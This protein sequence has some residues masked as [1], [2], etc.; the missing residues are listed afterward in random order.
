MK[1]ITLPNTKLITL[2]T[3]A[4]FCLAT[5]TIGAHADPTVTEVQA[6]TVHYADLNLNTQAGSAV[7]Y[8]RI[9]HAAAQVCGDVNSRQLKQARDAKACVDQA[10]L[11][12]VRFVNSP[13]LT[14]EYNAH[15]GVAQKPVNLAA[16]R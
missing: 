6:R 1:T 2:V 9:R 5:V 12:S 10:I 7:L 16:V 8:Q 11:S 13:K 15:F 14:S 4:G 3:V